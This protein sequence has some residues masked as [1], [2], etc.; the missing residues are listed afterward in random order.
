MK[1]FYETKNIDFWNELAR[2]H[3]QDSDYQLDTYDPKTYRLKD[4]ETAELGDIIGKKIL[5]LQC[6]IGLDSFALEMMGAEVTSIDY[7][8]DAINTATKLKRKFGLDA[9]FHCS[10]V[11]DLSELKLGEFDIIFTSYGVL[12]WLEHLDLWANTINLHLKNEGEL[13]VID[14]HP[15]AKIFSNPN[16]DNSAFEA[17]I[18][19]F[20]KSYS[21]PIKANFKYSYANSTHP[22][23]NQEQYIWFHSLSDIAL[24]LTNRGMYITKFQE[25]NKTF[26]KAF[27]QMSLGDDGWWR[28]GDEYLSLPLIF[29][30]RAK[31]FSKG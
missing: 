10:N 1:N 29:L 21:H 13:I 4:V 12:V 22:V 23:E 14:E 2:I 5:H 3:T 30:M 20:N 9:K 18:F 16:Q 26:Y 25:F 11:Y 27:S 8:L 6:H 17:K 24:S 31:K 28:F 19:R 15:S 7:S